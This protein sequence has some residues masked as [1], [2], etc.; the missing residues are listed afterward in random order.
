MTNDQKSDLD[1]TKIDEIKV[2]ENIEKYTSEKLADM[3]IAHRYLGMFEG[4]CIIAMEEL[5]SRRGAGDTFHFEKYIADNLATLPKL[6]FAKVLNLNSLIQI[7]GAK[8]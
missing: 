4:S 1:L 5:A 3:I 6:E 2:K 8:K 7:M